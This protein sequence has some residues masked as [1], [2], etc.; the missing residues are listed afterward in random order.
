M[1]TSEPLVR[2]PWKPKSSKDEV[3]NHWIGFTEGYTLPPSEFY[4]TLEEQLAA[5]KIPGLE[6]ARI[7]YP[8]GGLLSENRIYMRLIRE[9]LA[10]DT[11]AAPFGTGYFFSCRS[12]YSP[13]VL[14]LWHALVMCLLLYVI[15]R[16]LARFLG[17]DFAII[18]MAGLI[19]ATALVFRNTVVTGLSDLD[20]LLIKTPVLGPIYERWFRKDTYYRQDAR[21]VYL[22]AVSGLFRELAEEMTAAKGVKLVRQYERAP[23]LG[24]LYK[25]VAPRRQEQ[26]K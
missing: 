12:I 13:P 16:S 23:I 14:K 21:M 10:F 9:R 22:E 25:P 2:P 26:A 15:Y 7:E 18:A 3:I 5:R 11:C 24:E 1:N 4:S 8:E 19:G 6:I 17:F 20:A